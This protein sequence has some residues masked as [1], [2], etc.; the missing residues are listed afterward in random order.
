[1]Y[2]PYCV[3]KNRIKLL[4][5]QSAYKEPAYKESDFHSPIL[6]KEQ[7]HY[8]FIWNSGYKKTEFKSPNEFLILSGFY[9]MYNFYVILDVSIIN[10]FKAIHSYPQYIANVWL[11][12]DIKVADSR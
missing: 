5:I 6:T 12:I 10:L 1:M 3:F 8:T 9:C 4:H 7:V 2:T 11:E